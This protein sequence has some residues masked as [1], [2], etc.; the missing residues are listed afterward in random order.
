MA[1]C[2]D[3]EQTRANLIEE[4]NVAVDNG[5]EF[6]IEQLLGQINQNCSDLTNVG[7]LT[8]SLPAGTWMF[9]GNGFQGTITLG[10]FS[11]NRNFLP[12]LPEG[13][14]DCILIFT[15]TA[16]IDAPRVDNL[17]G[18][19]YGEKTHRTKFTRIGIPGGITQDYTGFLFANPTGNAPPTMAGTFTSTED[20]L[21][22][23]WFAIFQSP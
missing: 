1:S 3:L 13:E 6:Q 21:T 17:I 18:G 4:L 9:N 15:G 22:R 16:M 12:E 20:N 10:S 5:D 11:G 7:C 2:D 14:T 8:F 23:G 19:F